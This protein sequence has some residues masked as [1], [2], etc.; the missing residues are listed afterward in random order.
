M[1][2]IREIAPVTQEKLKEIA[3]GKFIARVGSTTNPENRANNYQH[4]GYAG[5]MYVAPT[6]NMMKAEDKLLG[7]GYGV[8]N[9]HE[10]SNAQETNGYIYAIKGK[11]MT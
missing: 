4:E 7:S 8:H 9:V 1:A 6:T 3:D 2:G 10:M 11:K 5:V